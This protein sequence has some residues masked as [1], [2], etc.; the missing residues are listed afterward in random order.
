MEGNGTSTLCVHSVQATHKLTSC[1]KSLLGPLDV[2]VQLVRGDVPLRNKQ[3]RWRDG[4]T[5]RPV[6]GRFH[7]LPS[8]SP[9]F[10]TPAAGRLC[11]YKLNS[12]QKDFP[13]TLSWNE[14]LRILETWLPWRLR[15]YVLSKGWQHR[16]RLYSVITKMATNCIDFQR[17]SS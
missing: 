13:R 16:T 8:L 15:Q 6:A 11:Y 1:G 17:N 12:E 9:G 7:Y 14:R 4:G 2:T 10:R 5:T 3:W